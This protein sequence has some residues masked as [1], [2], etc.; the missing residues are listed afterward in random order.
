MIF[1]H[2]RILTAAA[3]CILG[4]GL[5]GASAADKKTIQRDLNKT[6]DELTP[7][8]HIA[9]RAAAKAAYK[10]KK[11]GQ[12]NV[13]ADPGN[14]PL[15]N[16]QREGFQNKLAELLA[17]AT[18]AQIKYHWQPFI[19]RGL[20]RSTFEEHYC[21]LMFDIPA[22]YGRLLTTVPIYKTPYVLAYRDDKGLELS[23]LDDPKLKDLKIGVFQTSGVRRALAKRG[24]IDNVDLQL[25]THDGDLVPENQP[26]Y[27]VQRMLDGELDVAAV[28][29]PFAGW[30]KTM[31]NEP[32]AIQPINL[33]DDTVPMEFELAI[34]VRPTDV[35]L[36]YLLD[37]ALE[38]HEEEVEAILKEYGVPLVQCSK[39]VVPGDLPAHGSYIK[40]A[41]QKFEA[42]PDLATPDQVVTEERLEKWLEEGADPQQELANALIANDHERIRFLVSKGA[43]VNK[44]DLQGWTPLTSAARQ[45]HDKTIDLLVE[46][47]ADP[48]K[49]D[50]NGITPLAAALMRDHVPSIKTL[51]NHGADL[52]VPGQQEFRP[53]ALAVA[54]MKYEAA[55][56]LI[57]GG[58][59]ASIASGTEGLTPLMIIAAQTG[60]A[61]GSIFLPGSTRP[62]DIAKALLD[63]DA[64]VDAQAHNGMTALMIAAANNSAPMIGLLMDAG[65][66]PTV[67][68]A[69]NQTAEDVANLNDNQEAA[70]AIRVLSLTRASASPQAA[71]GDGGG[72]AKQ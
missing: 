63:K 66:D 64:N 7:S 12:L 16:I 1:P 14:M 11:L 48:N 20:T 4:L 15:S 60:P 62:T 17:K 45:R 56:A 34:G 55:K 41:D 8:E 13:C 36:K 19:E 37:W 6:F 23:G 70:Q 38:D 33:D 58:A 26:W 21:D 52:E 40:L 44:P 9:I 5:A 3:V 50:G 46:L 51:I 25:Q 49:A 69:Q 30:V 68:N 71:E 43:D 22:S 53:L 18:G 67:K 61:E 39:C 29:G 27:V 24:I 59:D 32:V 65:A 47:G 35:F 54:E 57:E 10:G 2:F 28:F 42:R 31:K 72:T